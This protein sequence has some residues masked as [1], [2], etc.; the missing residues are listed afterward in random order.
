MILLCVETSLS[1]LTEIYSIELVIELNFSLSSN[2]IDFFH[3]RTLIEISVV[4]EHEYFNY[5]ASLKVW[6]KL[7]IA[8]TKIFG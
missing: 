7:F 1:H 4:V 5:Y 3:D 8:L 6:M 2:S